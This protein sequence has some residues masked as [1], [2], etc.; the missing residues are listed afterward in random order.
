MRRL[1][2]L[3]M[4]F[5][6]GIPAAAHAASFDC[7][8]ARLQAELAVCS[9]PDLSAADDVLARAYHNRLAVSP[10]PLDIRNQQR[11]WLAIRNQCNSRN[12]LVALYQHRIN[13]LEQPAPVPPRLR[14]PE[15]Q[16]NV[17]DQDFRL[18]PIRPR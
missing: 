14:A 10:M 8:A 3:S 11:A 7:R 1:I 12:C 13:E 5:L 16:P 18:P 2:L 9:D 17:D 6:P 15:R 4:S